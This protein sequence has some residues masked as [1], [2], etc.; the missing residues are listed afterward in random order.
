MGNPQEEK[1][2]RFLKDKEI[3]LAGDQVWAFGDGPWQSAE[4]K[5]GRLYSSNWA[6]FRRKIPQVMYISE[7]GAYALRE[8]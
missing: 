7:E 4:T 8:A 2:Y 5:I 1:G 3:I 6:T